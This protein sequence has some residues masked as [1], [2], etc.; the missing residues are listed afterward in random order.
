MTPD[1][2]ASTLV[3]ILLAGVDISSTLP[4]C[5]TVLIESGDSCRVEVLDIEAMP[6]Y[7][8]DGIVAWA[9]SILE[10][11]KDVTSYC[12]AYAM[13]RSLIDVTYGTPHDEKCYQGVIDRQHYTVTWS[14]VT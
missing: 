13:G 3:E 5:P 1:F 9:R 10:G 14:R 12:I 11:C 2:G 8:V 6:D 4:L 7:N